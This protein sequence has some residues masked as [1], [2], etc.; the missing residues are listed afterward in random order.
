M[1]TSRVSADVQLIEPNPKTKTVTQRGGLMDVRRQGNQ[2]IAMAHRASRGT[3][4][5]RAEYCSHYVIGESGGAALLYEK[6]HSKE[7]R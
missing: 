1:L 2:F 4:M 6:A 3:S 7:G 5:S